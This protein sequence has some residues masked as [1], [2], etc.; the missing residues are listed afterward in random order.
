M[1]YQKEG[2]VDLNLLVYYHISQGLNPSQIAK[3][4]NWKKP[5]ISY[6]IANL[7][8]NSLI[9]KVGYGTWETTSKQV[10]IYHMDGVNFL[11]FFKVR[12]HAFQF[13]LILPKDLKN[14]NRRVEYLTKNNIKID[15]VGN[16]KRIPRITYKNYKIWLCNNSIIVYYPKYLSFFSN[17]AKDSRKDAIYNFYAI[18]SQIERILRANFKIKGKYLFKIPKRHYSLIKNEL[19]GFYLKENKKLEIRDK[20]NELWALIDNSMNLEEMEQVHKITAERDT[21]NIVEPFMNLLR[22]NPHIMQELILNITT[23][24]KILKGMQ[25]EI[26]EIIKY[27]NKK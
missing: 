22:D 6:Y 1:I 8:R 3:K 23:N 25:N 20:N 2:K 21:D 26:S 5:K 27:L 7:K 14:W 4:Y 11:N 19:A 13:K 16:L 12:G 9:K 24:T 15:F 10:Q 17:S 18:I